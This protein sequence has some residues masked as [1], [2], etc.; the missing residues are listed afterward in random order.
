MEST[1]TDAPTRL[2]PANN[3]A[4]PNAAA[5][6]SPAETQTTPCLNC[7]APLT[8]AFCATCGQGRAGRLTLATFAHE[9]TAQLLEVD[10][11]LMHTFVDLLRRPGAMI[12]GYV[13]GRR[14]KY[15]SPI[16]YVLI[17]SALS[18]LRSALTP[19]AARSIQEQAASITPT[20]RL[21][22][23][24]AQVDVFMRLED[25]VT[26]NKFAMDAFM[27]VPIVLTLR[28]LF[29]KR[30]V[31][32]A[33][34]SVFTCYTIGQATLI[35]VVVGTPLMLVASAKMESW[36]FIAA[37]LGYLLY[38]GLGFFGRSVGTG[39]RLMVSVALGVILI[40]SVVFLLP[41]AFAR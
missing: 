4:F 7:D 25:L 16:T 15:T 30:G 9:L 28:F 20:L 40:D 41:F 29:R 3:I 12:R 6:P 37:T 24:Q 34:V 14:R 31:N 21:V 22:Y 23:S 5:T 38:A 17:A 35:S 36:L 39:I 19:D 11:G 1:S 27:L 2:T 8:G 10:H 32:L 33:E 18:L 13:E 26:T